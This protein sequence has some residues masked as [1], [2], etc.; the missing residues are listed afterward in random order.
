MDWQTVIE[1][2]RSPY[3]LEGFAIIIGCIMFIMILGWRNSRKNRQLTDKIINFLMHSKSE[4]G[5][6]YRSNHAI[7]LELNIPENRVRRLSNRSNK[8]R[9]HP[10]KKQGWS[11]AA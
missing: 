4:L 7:S 3:A 11:L 5:C 1:L 10:K 9:R 8:I 2:A 6:D